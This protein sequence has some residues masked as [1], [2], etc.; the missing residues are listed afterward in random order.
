[1]KTFFRSLCV[2]CDRVLVL[3]THS[4][5]NCV[6]Q[7]ECGFTSFTHCTHEAGFQ[8]PDLLLLPITTSAAA[9]AASVL[10]CVQNEQKNR[11]GAQLECSRVPV[12]SVTVMIPPLSKG[13]WSGSKP[14]NV[15]G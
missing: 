11:R 5:E 7:S 15:T 9:P 14:G 1:M 4:F 3:P 13:L 6:F 12:R 8:I 2:T 10:L